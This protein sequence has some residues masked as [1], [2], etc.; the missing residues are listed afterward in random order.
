MNQRNNEKNI[1]KSKTIRKLLLIISD[2]EMQ[3]K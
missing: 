2:N 1:K 3:K